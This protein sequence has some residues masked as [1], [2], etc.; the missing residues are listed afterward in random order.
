MDEILVDDVNDASGNEDIGCGYFGAVCEDAA[1]F[2][3]SNNYLSAL[4][5]G[6]FCSICQSGT[7]QRGSSINDVVG[8]NGGNI[9]GRQIRQ[10]RANALE[11]S[12]AG[13]KNCDISE[14]I[15]FSEEL[16]GV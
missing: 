13:G 4:R 11:C 6:E 16:R 2:T 14:A 5:S 15:D 1:S 10:C 12:I 7:I 8:K 3:Y 9:G